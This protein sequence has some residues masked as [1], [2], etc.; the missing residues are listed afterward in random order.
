MIIRILGGNGAGKSHIVHQVLK[1]YS[2]KSDYPDYIQ[3]EGNRDGL[4]NVMVPG[5]YRIPNGG[6]DT[7]PSGKRLASAYAN[8]EEHVRAGWHV[9]C[10]VS[11]QKDKAARM[12]DMHRR[13]IQIRP[14]L[15]SESDDLRV[16]SVRSRGHNIRED[17]IRKSGRLAEAI[18]RDFAAAGVPILTLSRAGAFA[19]VVEHL[20][21][22]S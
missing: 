7:I 10:E 19:R 13:D 9:L 22:A 18:A 16:Q 17:L 6:M 2:D 1:L 5:H 11:S 12:I 8:I 21:G 4:Q 3:C 15:L 20:R 14:R